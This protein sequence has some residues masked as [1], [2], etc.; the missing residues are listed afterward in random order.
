MK[1]II[2]ILVIAC[3][4]EAVVTQAQSFTNNPYPK[5]ISVSGTAEMEIVP[6]EI[7]V[8]ITLTEYQKR[9]DHKT[10]LETIKTKFKETYRAI[11]IPDS[12]V[13][14]A[15]Y[16]GSNYNYYWWRRKRNTEVFSTITYQVKFKTSWTMDALVDKLD[17]QATQNFSI[18]SVSHSKIQELKRQLKIKA[19]QEAKEKGGYL[20][21]AVGEKLG[22]TLTINE[23]TE[24]RPLP[25][26]HPYYARGAY[27]E[28]QSRA[29]LDSA[30]MPNDPVA[31]VDFKKIKLKF[32]VNVVFA[33]K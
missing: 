24:E 31:E 22:E 20:T 26:H 13:S 30:R 10:D 9:G 15:S 29:K 25:P 6:D 11:G 32:E 5:T 8:N 27:D 12:L 33:L 14:I 21:E 19:V 1:K 17:D 7:F 3:L 16:S 23:P 2:P 28:Y 18:V 4:F